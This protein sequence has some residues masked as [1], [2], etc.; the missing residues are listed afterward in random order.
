[1]IGRSGALALAALLVAAPAAADKYPSKPIRA[2]A[3]QGPG[4]LS[5]VFMRVLAESLG[6]AL[7]GTV[8]VENRVGAA[9]SIGARVCADSEPDGYTI[10][11]L[12]NESMVINP[13][14]FTKMNFD[15]KQHL[16]P[17]TRLFFLQHTFA[18]NAS[19]GVKSFE[20]LAAYTKARPKTM[21][22]ITPS[23]SKVAFMEDF[24]KKH[25]TDFVR[26]PFKGG[27][28]AVNNMLSGTTP[29]AIF[30]IGNLI[31]HM[32][33]GKILAFAVDGDK[34]SPL[35]P[36][37]PT[38]KERGYTLGTWSSSF[39][40]HVPK[41]TPKAIVDKINR[42]VVKIGSDPEFQKK[43]LIARGLAPVFDSPEHFA[44]TMKAETGLGREVVV[45]SGLYPDI[46]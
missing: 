21:N 27:G 23:L 30:G 15:P 9:G 10:C 39:G 38:F 3:S 46:K 42:A 2:I 14:I 29:V 31:T 32:K 28:D 16:T 40:L 36:D 43:H 7:G 24:N 25:G 13:L 44:E 5:D 45:A 34:R 11:I 1:M 6:P 8:V 35:A 41:G 33:G 12:N 19:L 26:V 22:Y 18:V 37:I 4:G 20:E 17:V